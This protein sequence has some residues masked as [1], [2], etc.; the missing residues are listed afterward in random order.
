MRLFLYFCILFLSTKNG[1]FGQVQIIV[2]HVIDLGP[3]SEQSGLH[4]FEIRI[5]NLGGRSVSLLEVISGCGCNSVSQNLPIVVPA[6]SKILLPF[7]F[8]PIGMPGYFY[9]NI[10][11]KVSGVS[12][13]LVASVR[14]QV[15]RSRVPLEYTKYFAYDQELF[16]TLEPKYQ[17]FKAG[18]NDFS[19]SKQVYVR[20]ESCASNV[21]TRIYASN[22]ALAAARAAQAGVL[23][24]KILKSYAIDTAKVLIMPTK[25]IV[26]GPLY[27]ND[28]KTNG[29]KYAIFQYVKI[30]VF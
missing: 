12:K 27:Q 30:R 10:K 25:N 23:I 15:I 19:S 21:P 16:D 13:P 29:S 28:Y 2:Q 7:T 5:E 9:K 1:I 22:Y 17:D 6:N 3:I 24:R 26:D 11:I 20:I 4:N 18:L 8:N 14:G